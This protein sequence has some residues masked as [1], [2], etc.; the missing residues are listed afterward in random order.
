MP[1]FYKF[2]SIA[3]NLYWKVFRVCLFDIQNKSMR[4]SDLYLTEE[5]LFR[6]QK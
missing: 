5:E 3:G 4:L 1:S 6:F 2:L